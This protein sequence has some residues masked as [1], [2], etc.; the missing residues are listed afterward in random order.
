MDANAPVLAQHWYATLA[1]V[2]AGT[3]SIPSLKTIRVA[4]LL[5]QEGLYERSGVDRK[6]IM[7]AEAGRPVRISTARR[8]ADALGVSYGRL[9]KAPQESH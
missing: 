9:L 3:V 8:L 1:L 2:A 4:K 6:T 7:R 5:T